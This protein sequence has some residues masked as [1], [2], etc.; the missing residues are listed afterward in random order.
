[1]TK[2]TPE[3]WTAKIDRRSDREIGSYVAQAEIFAGGQ[4]IGSA[5]CRDYA[6]AEA[7]IRRIVACVNA[8]PKVELLLRLIGTDD[9]EGLRDMRNLRDEIR[10]ILRGEG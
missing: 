9:P 5:A 3:P 7:N 4:W 6:D 10:A 1:M 8:M 2:H